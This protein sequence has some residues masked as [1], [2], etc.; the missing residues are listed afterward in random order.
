MQANIKKKIL[1][2]AQ[3]KAEDE[4]GEGAKTPKKSPKAGKTTTSRKRVRKVAED[5]GDEE[6]F[7]AKARKARKKAKAAPKQ[8]RASISVT[9]VRLVVDRTADAM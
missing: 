9:D 3:P 7:G 4:A 6:G 1:A 8:V 5:E 2:A